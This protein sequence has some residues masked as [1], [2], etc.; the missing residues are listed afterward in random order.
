MA[1]N[2]GGL[3]GVVIFYVII[4]AIG[5]YASRKNKGKSSMEDVMLAGRNIGMFL[6]VFTMT[7]TWVGGGYI[8][9]TAQSIYDTGLIWAQAPWA[10]SLS[11]FING[12]FFATHLRKQRYVTMLDPYQIKYGDRVGVLMF[13]AAYSGEIFWSSAILAALGST[14][15]VILGIDKTLAIIVSTCIAMSYTLFGGL[16]SVAYTD[17]LQLSCIFFGLWLAIPFAM[18]NE[19]VTS[20]TETNWF[21]TW[22]NKYTGVWIEGVLLLS[23]GGVPWQAYFQRVLSAK[24]PRYARIL[25]FAGA[26]GC[27]IMTIPSFLMGAIGASTNWNETAYGQEITDS[28]IVLP[29][30]LQYLTPQ[31]VSIIGLG[32]VCAAVMSSADSSLL[33]TS[34][35]FARN[36]YKRIIRPNASEREIIWVMRCSILVSGTIASTLAITI[37]SIYGLFYLCSDFVYVVL[38][39]QL[40]CVVYVSFSNTY[41]VLVGYFLGLILRLGGGEPL[42]GLKP[43]IEYPFYENGEQLFPFRTFAMLVSL[44]TLCVVSALFHYLFTNN[45]L[46]KKWDLLKCVTNI[47]SEEDERKNAFKTQNGLTVDVGLSMLT[48]NE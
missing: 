2:W 31:V 21:G 11:L 43:F 25:S 10:Y 37:D 41:G 32:A 8:N 48:N 7:A 15:S 13:L 3:I 24:T 18:T 39:P 46:D 14:F 1:V 6:G 45:I 38:F 33:S 9:G 23:L 30:V 36:V 12:L 29:L 17:V 44:T 34:S 16:Y 27:M 5:I 26:A 4:L 42:L 35:M 47:P 22:E 28:N 40:V 20:I 19:H